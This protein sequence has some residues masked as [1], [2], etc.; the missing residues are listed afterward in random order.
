MEEVLSEKPFIK[1][2]NDDCINIM[3][4]MA[5]KSVDLCLCDPPYGIGAS[6]VKKGGR[7]DGNSFAESKYY[8][9]SDWD[10]NKPSKEIFAE[11][12]RVSK[13]QIVFGGEH[14]SHLLPQS[15][16]WIFWDKETG[17]NQ[18]ADGEL[19]WTSFDKA[20]RKV[21]FQWKGMF[22]GNMK[23][24][25]YRWHPTQK[26][27]AV[28]RWI[29]EKYSEDNQTIIDPF[30]GS[31]TTGVACKEL[32]RNF[33]GIEIDKGYYEI[34]QKRIAQATQELFV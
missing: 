8:E 25:E 34:A 21:T 3:R 31:G 6:N 32:G 23:E 26:P 15:R 30:M 5:D 10:N 28:I 12:F 20:L 19:A 33:I 4:K 7:R 9:P 17:D 11:M 2:V 1:L 18:Y 13:N 27:V 22:Q 24:K 16:G 14:L 29:L